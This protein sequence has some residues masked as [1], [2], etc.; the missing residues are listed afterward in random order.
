MKEF[1]KSTDKDAYL[2]FPPLNLVLEDDE[3]MC[4]VCEG[5]GGWNLEPFAYYKSMIR[6]K[7]EDTPANRHTRAHFRCVCSHCNGWGKVKM[8]E[9]CPGH[10]W[11]HHHKHA[12][13]RCLNT[14]KCKLCGKLWEVDSSD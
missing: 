1:L 10:I 11:E 2:D 14:Y 7:I 13:F 6:G 3:K 4:P 9:M 8:S 12:Y 5:H